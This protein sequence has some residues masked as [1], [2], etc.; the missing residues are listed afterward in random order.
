MM[1][2][3]APRLRPD[4][5]AISYQ[6]AIFFPSLSTRTAT[7]VDIFATASHY[8]PENALLLGDGNGAF[9]RVVTGDVLVTPPSRRRR[10]AR[11]DRAVA[12][13][14]T[15][16]GIVDIFVW[17]STASYINDAGDPIATPSMGS[18]TQVPETAHNLLLAGN[19]DGTFVSTDTSVARCRS[20]VST[21]AL[22]GDG[23]WINDELCVPDGTGGLA[24]I[25]HLDDATL[26]MFGHVYTTMSGQPYTTSPMRGR[27]PRTAVGDM[28]G[29][30]HADIF[31]A[32]GAYTWPTEK[33]KLYLA[34]VNGGFA[35]VTSAP[36][37]EKL[38]VARRQLSGSAGAW[39]QKEAT[40]K[41]LSQ[42][43]CTAISG[44]DWWNQL[45]AAAYGGDLDACLA[46]LSLD[47]REAGMVLQ[48]IVNV[49][50]LY[51][52]VVAKG[53]I[54]KLAVYNGIKEIDLLLQS[55]VKGAIESKMIAVTFARP[56]LVAYLCSLS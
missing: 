40:G 43:A 25:V 31:I 28:D 52:V 56:V 1:G 50:E 16:D 42:A 41:I 15:G 30:G 12:A 54:E 33:N 10:S 24:H 4:L 48:G 39:S 20:A 27:R 29:D 46:L 44:T 13:D 21:A 26:D 14:V 38:V 11:C 51:G 35:H 47:R 45:M 5:S 7:D 34:D 32:G 37:V 22:L 17:C 19:G 9:T 36:L 55:A 18:I 8:S 3:V 6:G 53:D 23:E 2:S 49:T